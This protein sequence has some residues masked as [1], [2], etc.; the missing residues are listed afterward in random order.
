V[1]TCSGYYLVAH[2]QIIDYFTRACHWYLSL[3]IQIRF[4]LHT[5]PILSLFNIILPSVPWF[6]TGVS[7]LYFTICPMHM[8]CVCDI[9]DLISLELFCL[10]HL[11]WLD[12]YHCLALI[13]QHTIYFKIRTKQLQNFQYDRAVLLRPP[14]CH[15]QVKQDHFLHL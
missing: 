9:L 7:C 14:T 10:M 5:T 3:S 4:C 13:M 1:L 12:V 2:T 8:T 11:A 6:L 15:I